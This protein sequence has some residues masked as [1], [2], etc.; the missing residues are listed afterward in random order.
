MLPMSFVTSST[1]SPCRGRDHGVAGT[2]VPPAPPPALLVH[3]HRRDLERVWACRGRMG[4]M[5]CEEANTPRGQLWGLPPPRKPPHGIG[6]D[7]RP[8]LDLLK[9]PAKLLLRSE[10]QRPLVERPLLGLR[11]RLGRGGEVEGQRI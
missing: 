11:L 4:V 6:V 10:V 7:R 8:L 9:C 1:Y 5:L 3:R 2:R